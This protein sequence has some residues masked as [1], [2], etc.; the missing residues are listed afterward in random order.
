L[1]FI[2]SRD[3]F[4]EYD[5]QKFYLKVKSVEALSDF[6]LAQLLI[7]FNGSLLKN[8][9]KRV[10]NEFRGT[11]KIVLFRK[12][13]VP[14]WLKKDMELDEIKYLYLLFIPLLVVLFFSI[15]LKVKAARIWDLELIKKTKSFFKPVLNW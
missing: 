6:H 9:V 10:I 5:L 7:N 15:L 13:L 12:S 8:E 4:E 11:H 3:W 14:L 2:V 1:A